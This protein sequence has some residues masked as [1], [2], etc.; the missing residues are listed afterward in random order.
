MRS[1]FPSSFAKRHYTWALIWN[2]EGHELRPLPLK[3]IKNVQFGYHG[4]KLGH[5]FF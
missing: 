2:W 5:M 1:R 3:A 4:N